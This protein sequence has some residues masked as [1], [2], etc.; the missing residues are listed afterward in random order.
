MARPKRIDLPFCLY[1]VISRTNSGDTAFQSQYEQKKFLEYLAKYC[2]LFHY[3]I[4]AWCI[5]KTH[6]H[7]LLESGPLPRISELMRRLLT[8]YTVYFNRRHK[9]HGHLFQGRFKSYVVEKA[10][11]LLVL[12]RY[13]HLN[14]LQTKSPKDPFQYPG[15]SL[16]YYL[17][18]SEPVFL[19]TS[20]T[21]SWFNGDRKKYGQ[22]IREGLKQELRLEIHQQRFIGGEKFA[23]RIRKR[24]R[25]RDQAGS[26]A[27]K[28]L[29]ISKRRNWEEE[30]KEAKKILSKVAKYYQ[31]HPDIIKNGYWARGNIGKARTILI[32][33]F[34]ERLAWTGKQIGGY[35]GIKKG[36]Y[37]YLKKLGENKELRRDY[38]SLKKVIQGGV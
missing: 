25:Q 12:S 8:A 15:S 18:G 1:H 22:Y 23:H 14:P 34:R 33:L 28:A 29:E 9:R 7:L 36:L 32:G 6:F 20:E 38:E 16:S 37:G 11:Y 10:D 21:L 26:R 30:Q 35:L 27:H 24:L 5:M 31:V 4:H 2:E 17:N 13:I 19:H 3:R